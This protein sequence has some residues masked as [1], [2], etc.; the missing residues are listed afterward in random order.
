MGLTDASASSITL[1]PR[2]SWDAK[3]PPWTDGKGN[4]EKFK[5]AGEDWKAFHDTLPDISPNRIATL[6]QGIVLKS[7]LYGQAADQCL[8]NILQI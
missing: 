2:F 5:V 4:E 8:L 1:R 7:Q 3:T 6:V